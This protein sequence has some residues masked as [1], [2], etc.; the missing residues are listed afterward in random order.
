MLLD[1]I[2]LD[3]AGATPY[4]VSTIHEH[5]K[6]LTTNLF[7]N[8][9]S[10]SP[11]SVATTV[12][13][14]KIRERILGLFR[15]S[16]EVF[17]VV[18]VANATAGIKLIADGFCGSPNGFRYKYL[19]D[20]HTSLVGVSALAQQTKCL[21]G[22][23]A[24]SWLREG[25]VNHDNRPGLFAYPAQSNFDGRRFPLNW[26]TKLRETHPGWYSLLDAASYLTTTPLDFS[27]AAMA[28]DFTVLS[29]YKIF[30]YPDL[31]AIIVKRDAGPILLQRRY[32]GG[33]T[34]AAITSDSFHA[35]RKVLH[36]ALED[37]TLP[38]HTILAL[39]AS[40][41]NHT[42]LFGSQIN[43][44]RHASIVTRLMY[45]LL[46]SLRHYN[47]TP[48][49]EL[50]SE[51]NHGP[52][53]AFNLL[54]ANGTQVG[55]ASFEKMSSLRNIA[56]RTGGMCNPGGVEKHLDLHDWEVERNYGLG[57]V[58]GDDLDIV[59]GKSTG[60]I[61][62]SFGACSTV[63]EV[64]AFVDF[65]REFYIEKQTISLVSSEQRSAMTIQS[66]YLCIIL[67]MTLLIVDPIKSCHAFSVPQ[68]VAWPLTSYG[69]L[70]DREYFLISAT[71][72][73]ALSQKQYPK[74]AL[75]RPTI[76]LENRIML[77]SSP[78]SP[79]V[80]EIPLDIDIPSSITNG[81]LTVREDT[82]LCA[83]TIR[84]LIF[85]SPSIDTFFSSVL[86]VECSLAM[87]HPANSTDMRYFK[88][89]ASSSSQPNSHTDS[90]AQKREIW[91]SN[92]SPY[93]LISD[94]SV[95]ALSLATGKR[96]MI[97]PTV[98]RPNFVLSGNAAYTEDSF[99]RIRIGDVG[100]DILGQCRRCH[101]VCVDPERGVKEKG[102]GDVY[103]GLGKTRKKDTGGVVFGV[104]MGLHGVTNG[105]VRVGDPVTVDEVV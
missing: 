47:G 104:H 14:A 67:S 40:L 8:P 99:K 32:F 68:G 19:R 62:I 95:T 90:L 13:I 6:D 103:L 4:P 20:V 27:N 69:L 7:S 54:A 37:G 56:L 75:I 43:V 34:R 55:F 53:I 94:S 92:E 26:I 51:P 79:T 100:F 83:D 38:F 88:P 96:E 97:S 82:R 105:V 1:T 45:T 11:S 31:G 58:C 49:C 2:Y 22:D 42:R 70:F 81:I 73:R 33:G 12:R 36:D 10:R 59:E 21:S 72:G 66:V 30:G 23:E 60:V 86:G 71:G 77:V 24:E 91:L 5:S 48:V 61:R 84:S 64:L 85:T 9:H 52:I 63:E 76:D 80:L 17:D 87:Y 16:P 50:Y 44:S 65:V 102:G 41:N 98:F 89:D 46:S 3:H 35:P 57:K 78:S 101:M 29:F 28:P 18:F 25:E 93:L 74:M 39:D 15:A